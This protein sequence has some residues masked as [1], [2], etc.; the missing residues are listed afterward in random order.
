MKFRIESDSFGSLKVPSNKLWG[1]QTQ[2]SL[3]NFKIGNEIMPSGLVR[4]LGIIKLCAAET[5]IEQ[6]LIDKRIGLAIIKA[7]KEVA[8][9]KW[10]DHFRV[11][12][13]HHSRDTHR[14]WLSKCH[15]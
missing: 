4:A 2:R 10:D 6:N 8:E 13:P 12:L 3:K 1:A 5:N 14:P 15:S 9:G 7:A 11:S